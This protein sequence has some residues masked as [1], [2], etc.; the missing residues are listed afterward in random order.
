MSEFLIQP[1][2]SISAFAH[3]KFELLP[4]DFAQ[5]TI[6]QVTTVKEPCLHTHIFGAWTQL[7]CCRFW[8]YTA[9]ASIVRF[10]ANHTTPVLSYLSN[11]IVPLVKVPS[12]S[13]THDTVPCMS[14]HFD[15]GHSHIT[16]S[17]RW[18]KWISLDLWHSEV[19]LARTTS[20]YPFK[21]HRDIPCIA[22]SDSL[23]N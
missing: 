2:S 7:Q 17:C 14:T 20:F 8:G 16:L 5:M 21:L 6:E 18:L 12:L 10:I 23:N 22:F 9:C 11:Y 15:K 13:S 4:Y 19:K 3:L 1:N